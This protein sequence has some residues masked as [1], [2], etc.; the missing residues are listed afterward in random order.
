MKI[1]ALHQHYWPEIAATGQLLQDICEDMV[2]GGHEVTVLCGQPSYRLI[3]G[4]PRHCA[5]VEQVNGVQV[6]RVWSYVPAV[7][8]TAN[9]LLLYGS[10]FV[11]SLAGAVR[12][13]RPDVAFIMSSPP[14]L[15]GAAGTV[16]QE[17]RDIPFVY[18]VQDLYPDVAINIGLLQ[19]GIL[20]SAID[21]ASSL[22]YRAASESITLS[23]GMAARLVEKGVVSERINVIPNWAD[24]VA[25]EP[26]PRDNDFAREHGLVDSFVVQY[27]GNVGLSQGLSLLVD[28]ADLL[29]HHPITFAIIGDGDARASLQAEAT[30][31][32]LT[33]I[34]FLPPQE[35][36]VLPNLLAS[37]DVG[38]VS[39][40]SRVSTDLVPSK[41][42]GI[43]AAARPVLAAVEHSSEVARVVERHACGKVVTPENAAALVDGILSLSQNESIKQM[44]QAGRQAAEK[45]Y[46]RSICTQRYEEVL[47]RVARRESSRR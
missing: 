16:L 34:K 6:R 27:S 40:K 21:W 30:R 26:Q 41:L 43:L 14:L 36:T 11:S 44:G 28:A 42:Y 4:I 1:L 10:Y 19:P 9:R 35:R 24:T 20:C 39:M 25:I 47:A 29:R 31:R 45:Y 37:C 8:S 17:L 5:K 7:R 13:S 18:S 33:N 3:D 32:S 38:L 23:N 22:I 12:E 46:A 2:R 15:L